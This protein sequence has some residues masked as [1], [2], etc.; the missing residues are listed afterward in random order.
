MTWVSGLDGEG[1]MGELTY[2]L[3]VPMPPYMAWALAVIRGGAA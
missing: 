3:P 1:V 2:H